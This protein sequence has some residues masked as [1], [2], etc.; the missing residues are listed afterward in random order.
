MQN[1]IEVVGE[2]FVCTTQWWP[3]F[4]AARLHKS[5]VCRIVQ[6]LKAR[7]SPELIGKEDVRTGVVECNRAQNVVA[8]RI[9]CSPLLWVL[10][11]DIRL[12]A[13]LCDDAEV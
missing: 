10:V 9:G 2:H 4:V 3:H 7:W 5:E 8:R 1:A 6:R 13:R 12:P 11:R